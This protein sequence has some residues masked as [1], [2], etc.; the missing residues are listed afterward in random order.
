[1]YITCTFLIFPVL[2]IVGLS[3]SIVYDE[4]T[5][6]YSTPTT[7]DIGQTLSLMMGTVGYG[8]GVLTYV[9]GKHSL[10]YAKNVYN[11]KNVMN[12]FHEEYHKILKDGRN[13]IA[14]TDEEHRV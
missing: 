10:Q 7:I 14:D 12:E 11:C 9:Y 3:G 1:M 2:G 5:Y 8:V 4:F 13:V 6:Q